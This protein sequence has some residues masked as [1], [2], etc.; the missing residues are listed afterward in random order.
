MISGYE[1]Y[2]VLDCVVIVK[3]DELH[4]D[5]SYIVE[6]SVRQGNPVLYW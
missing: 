1:I 2:F 6:K 3:L 5:I 4:E